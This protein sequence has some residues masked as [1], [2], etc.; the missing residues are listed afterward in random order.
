M[1]WKQFSKETSRLTLLDNA[2]SILSS[3]N[4]FGVM[5]DLG[6]E[7]SKPTPT[8][9]IVH[10]SAQRAAWHDGYVQA[11]EDMYYFRERYVSEGINIKPRPNFGA[12]DKL[13][14]EGEITEDEYRELTESEQQ[15]ISKR[16]IK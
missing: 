4:F 6:S 13:L 14:K 7:R 12:A 9:D 5:L 15:R 11:L 16:S 8:E 10:T 2:L 1:I 3:I